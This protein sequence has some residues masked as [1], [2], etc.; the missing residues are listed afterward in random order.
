MSEPDRRPCQR[1]SRPALVETL[2]ATGGYCRRCSPGQPPPP[3]NP[4]SAPPDPQ[5]GS[6][7]GTRRFTSPA[8][9]ADE[10]LVPVFI[11]SLAAVLINHERAKGQPLTEAEVLTIRD[12]CAVVMLQ[13]PDADALA[14]RRGYLDI[15]PDRCWPE[16][17]A[18]RSSLLEPG[19]D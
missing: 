7:H 18:L 2:R 8:D 1:C 15:D 16:W 6:F 3:P 4:P 19:G 10:D 12:K 5:G 13:R 9:R 11:P 14:T 17:L